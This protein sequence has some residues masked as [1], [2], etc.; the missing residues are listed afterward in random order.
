MKTVKKR[1]REG[2]TN[3]ST[4][5]KLLKGEKPRLVFRKTNKFVIGQYVLSNEAKDKIVFGI[6]SKALLK[7]GWPEK[8]KG[9]LKSIP[10]SYFTGYLISK[11]ILKDKLETPIVDLGMLRTLGKTKI[12]GFIKGLIDGGL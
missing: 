10:A 7:Q 1:R 6:T 9:S 8:M 3:Y 4:R 2:K 12:F 11:K 5:L